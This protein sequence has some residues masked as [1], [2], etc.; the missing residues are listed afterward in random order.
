MDQ[1]ALDQLND[2]K[3]LALE[4][5]ERSHSEILERIDAGQ[6]EVEIYVDG[7]EIGVAYTFRNDAHLL[8]MLAPL[9]PIPEKVVQEIVAVFM[10]SP[11]ELS[12]RE[13]PFGRYFMQSPY[14]NDPEGYVAFTQQMKEIDPPPQSFNPECN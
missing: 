11:Q 7:Q 6:H 3:K 2:L 12:M 9:K 14:P 13:H 10:D 1:D 5:S 4:D 8:T